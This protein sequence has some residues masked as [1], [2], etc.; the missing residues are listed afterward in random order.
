[1]KEGNEWEIFLGKS[2]NRIDILAALVST[3]FAVYL[4]SE[5]S[6]VSQRVSTEQPSV[7]HVASAFTF[8]AVAAWWSVA[9]RSFYLRNLQRSR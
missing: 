3:A 9:K 4:W 1:M 6:G 8:T 2:L 7:W 5:F